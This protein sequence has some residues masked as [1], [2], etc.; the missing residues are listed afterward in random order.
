MA[1]K[2]KKA[3]VRGEKRFRPKRPRVIKVH[4][5]KEITAMAPPDLLVPLDFQEVVLG[6]RNRR[7][8]H[9]WKP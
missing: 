4:V 5:I 1:P 8:D 2:K 6:M 3:S 9:L 7:R